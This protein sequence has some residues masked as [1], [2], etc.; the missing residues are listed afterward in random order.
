MTVRRRGGSVV[1]G[2][3]RMGGGLDGI[4]NFGSELF[5]CLPHRTDKLAN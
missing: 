2:T 3:L 5:C 4:Q 1:D